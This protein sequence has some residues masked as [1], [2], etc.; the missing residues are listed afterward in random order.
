MSENTDDIGSPRERLNR[1]YEDP[2]FHD[3][4]EPLAPDETPPLAQ[5]L[6]A[7]GKANRKLPPRRRYE[8][9]D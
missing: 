4:D 6:P 7:R 9:D 5:R 8:Y 3:E 1:E 2:H